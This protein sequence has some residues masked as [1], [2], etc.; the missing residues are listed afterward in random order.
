MVKFDVKVKEDKYLRIN[1]VLA[2]N[3]SNKY[4]G[5]CSNK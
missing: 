3:F 4:C 1:R 2:Y 5:K